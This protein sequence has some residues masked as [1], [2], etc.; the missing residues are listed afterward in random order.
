AYFYPSAIGGSI[1]CQP[2]HV[3]T[4]ILYISDSAEF[5]YWIDSAANLGKDIAARNSSLS[6]HHIPDNF[7]KADLENLQKKSKIM[8]YLSSLTLESPTNTSCS[9]LVMS[10]SGLNSGTPVVWINAPPASLKYINLSSKKHKT[11]NSSGSGKIMVTS[12]NKRDKPKYPSILVSEE[13]FGI[14]LHTNHIN[15]IK[16]HPSKKTDVVDILKKNNITNFTFFKS[17]KLTHGH[18]SSWVLSDGIISKVRNTVSK[19]KQHIQKRHSII[20]FHLM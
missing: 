4:L 15:L 18:T 3:I 17:Q 14:E 1:F 19:Y 20:D 2:L 6:R 7:N 8:T 13:F 9:Q 12:A 10:R 5:K 11:N 16:I